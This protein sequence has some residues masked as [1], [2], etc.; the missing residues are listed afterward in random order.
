MIPNN[1]IPTHPGEILLKEFLEPMKMSQTQLAGEM[2][3]PIQ[4]I[5]TLI[6]GKRGITPETAILLSRFFRTSPEFWMN[7]QAS[8]D[9][10]VAEQKMM[11]GYLC[12]QD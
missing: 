11:K 4:R 3:I 10:A 12:R 8:Y 1:R 2:G 7:L 9:L 6:S 5:N